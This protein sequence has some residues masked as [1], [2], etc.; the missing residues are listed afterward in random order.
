MKTFRNMKIGAR[1]GIGFTSVLVILLGLTTL[2]WFRF[3]DLSH[4]MESVVQERFLAV[5]QATDIVNGVHGVE[6]ITRDLILMSDPGRIQAAD[7]KIP[8]ISAAITGMQDS[9][10]VALTG[11][12]RALLE[13]W[14]QAR[15][16]YLPF[17]NQS[18]ELARM[19]E[20]GQATDLL[21]GDMARARDVYIEALD[22]LIAFEMEGAR[23]DGAVAI[24]T[25]ARAQTILL[26]S[27]LIALALGIW[28]AIWITRS[29][30]R[31][32]TSIAEAAKAVAHGDFSQRID[33]ESEDEI[34]ELAQ[35]FQTVSE[36]V[37]GLVADMNNMSR[38][39]DLGDIDV[40]MAVDRYEGAFLEMADGVN[41]MVNGHI[42][43]KKKAMACVAEFGKGNFDAELERFP[44]KKAFINDTV[45]AV[46]ENLKRVSGDLGGLIESAKAGELATRADTQRFAGDWKTMVQGVNDLLDA[47]TGPIQEAQVVLEK[48]AARDMTAR[49]VGEYRGDHARIKNALNQAVENLDTGLGQVASSSDQV[50]S[51]AEQISSGSQALAQGTSEQASTLEEVASSAQELGSQAEQSAAHAREAKGLSDGARDGADKG[52][53]SMRRLSQAMEKI[54]ASSDETAK[55]VKTIDEIAFQTNLLALNAA[56]E[57]AR[58]GDAGKGFAVVAE[59]VRNLAMRSAEA[60]KTTAQLIEESVTNAEGGVTLNEETMTNLEA[61]QKQIFQVSEVMDEI[62]AGADQ[63]AGGIDQI[64]TALEQMN[65][66]TQQTAANAEESSSASEELTAQAEEM[67]AMVGRYR[68]TGGSIEGARP[69]A[70]ESPAL[71]SFQPSPSVG[72]KPNGNGHFIPLDEDDVNAVLGDF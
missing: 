43:V 25:A 18:R 20:D 29:I 52:V 36:T 72:K 4:R 47:V 31:P 13:E 8:Q 57:A 14:M 56:V 55:I 27:A 70:K 5:R 19:D 45:E 3:N 62:A 10:K 40:V 17:L 51:A 22:D 50:A 46:R 48:V 41:K 34:G 7:A 66:V 9:L 67:R 64:N 42:N 54:K 38:E 11:E 33:A 69:T 24:T 49:V 63:Q 1:I 71:P 6:E 44:G 59:E 61:I 53:D 39:H 2:S 12:G 58:A 15:K 32:V 35:S 65:Q 21:F 68:I 23:Q 16:A 26:I 28:V 37:Q 60:A 30:S